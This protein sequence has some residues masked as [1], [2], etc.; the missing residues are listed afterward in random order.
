[1]MVNFGEFLSNSAPDGRLTTFFMLE[2]PVIFPPVS[3]KILRRSPRRRARVPGRFA[4]APAV[5]GS[6]CGASFSR[7]ASSVLFPAVAGYLEGRTGRPRDTR[8][9]GPVGVVQ[10]YLPGMTICAKTPTGREIFMLRCEA[11]VYGG[12][13]KVRV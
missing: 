11:A 6:L 5:E 9:R 8:P 3:F 4:E 13:Q 7:G 12:L 1:V 2:H 10:G